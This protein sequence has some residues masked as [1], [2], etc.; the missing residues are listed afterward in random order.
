MLRRQAGPSQGEVCVV[1]RKI[2]AAGAH[3]IDWAGMQDVV[4]LLDAFE[5][6]MDSKTA[7]RH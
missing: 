7:R 3:A 2:A 5:A 4:P 1:Q 6:A